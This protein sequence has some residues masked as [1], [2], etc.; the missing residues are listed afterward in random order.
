MQVEVLAE[1][2][3]LEQMVGDWTFEIE[4]EMEPGAEPGR[5][6]GRE[7]VRSLG[8]IWV[9]A[10]GR[11]DDASDPHLS[12][13]TLGF[14][15][16]KGRCVGSFVSSMMPGMWVYEGELDPSSSKLVLNTRGPSA[17]GDGTTADY[18]DTIEF[19]S[20]DHRILTSSYQDAAG[21]WQLF[22]TAH[23]RSAS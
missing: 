22:M 16:A 11:S 7:S 15:P 18:R 19:A 1:H 13:M 5:H 12:V 20:P 3:W 4:A 9:V 17:A 2:R 8:G 6:T 21:E 14:D 23:Y 10:E